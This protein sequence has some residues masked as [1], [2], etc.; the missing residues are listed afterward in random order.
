MG[1]VKTGVI[2]CRAPSA[3]TQGHRRVGGSKADSSG[4][5]VSHH[6]P[7]P[8]I[9]KSLGL[10]SAHFRRHGSLD[11]FPEEFRVQVR[12]AIYSNPDLSFAL[13]LLA[14]YRKLLFQHSSV[15]PYLV[16]LDVEAFPS[17]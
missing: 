7:S 16:P 4:I 11:T 9:A 10:L 3:A 13:E 2:S 6:C 15:F 12:Q 8:S 5:S 1:Q 14:Q 17:L